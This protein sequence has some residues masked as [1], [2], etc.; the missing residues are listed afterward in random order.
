MGKTGAGKTTAV[1]RLFG[2]DWQT[3]S[4]VACTRELN[5]ALVSLPSQEPSYRIQVVDTPGIAESQHMDEYYWEQYEQAVLGAA[6]LL[7]FFQ[8]DT[9]V[10]KP[11]QLMLKKLSPLLSES[12]CLIVCL[13]QVDNMGPGD[14][15]IVQNKP[16]HAQLANLELKIDDLHEKL[17]KVVRLDRASIIPCS[18]KCGF[19][20]SEMLDMLVGGL[21]EPQSI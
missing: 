2:L 9:R 10:Y 20:L 4:A 14:W 5:Q 13:S 16:S 3:D 17:S 19:G 1:N 18:I 12:T 11:D 21:N 15:D 8:A 7:W 6:V